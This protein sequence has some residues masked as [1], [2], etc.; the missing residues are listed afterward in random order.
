MSSP[1][2]DVVEEGESQHSLMSAPD[3][4]AGEAVVVVGLETA[5]Q[6]NHPSV[7][8][9][10]DALFRQAVVLV[11]SDQNHQLLVGQRNDY[12]LIHW[13]FVA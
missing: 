8:G 11:V 13:K 1:S 12:E 10:W 4:V 2:E 5:I 3:P 9:T 7:P 6:K